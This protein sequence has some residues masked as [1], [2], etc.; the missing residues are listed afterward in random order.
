MA[1]PCWDYRLTPDLIELRNLALVAE[2]ILESALS[3]KESRG[4]HYSLDYPALLPEARDTVLR[5][6]SASQLWRDKISGDPP[7]SAM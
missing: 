6:P 5:R 2:L 3:R 1:W 4:L 7:M